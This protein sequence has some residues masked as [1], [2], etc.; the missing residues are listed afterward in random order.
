MSM[1]KIQKRNGTIV[2]FQ[3]Q[4]I[5]Q[6]IHN[7]AKASR[8]DLEEAVVLAILQDIEQKLVVSFADAIPHVE[9]VQDIV[10]QTLIHFDYA[11]IAKAYILYR[12]TRRKAREGRQVTV[13]VSATIDEYL[14]R[15]DWRVN[16]NSNQ[17]YSLGGMILNTSGKVTANYWLSHIYPT[18]IGN[19]HRNAD[20]HIHDLDMFL[21]RHPRSREHLIKPI[22]P[23]RH[24]EL[25]HYV[26]MV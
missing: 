13:D 16:A 19:V 7:A 12:E 26:I 14:H 10:E 2:S 24:H 3:S 8:N 21:T 6:A 11:P 25:R 1:S 20:M 22:T 5:A 4:K 17:G 15:A 18:A 9:Q 23:L